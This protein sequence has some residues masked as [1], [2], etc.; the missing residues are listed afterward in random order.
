MVWSKSYFLAEINQV[1]RK[2][3]EKKFAN[4]SPCSTAESGFVNQKNVCSVRLHP[5]HGFLWER[6]VPY[7][8]LTIWREPFHQ[9]AGT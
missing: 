8:D 6:E 1:T 3:F 7:T 4:I 9:L 5:T 2:T